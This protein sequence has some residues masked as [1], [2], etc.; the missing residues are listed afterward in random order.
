MRVILADDHAP[1][2]AGV[3]I[4]LEEAG[5]DVVGEAPT[6]RQAVE[7]AVDLQPDICL[8]DVHMPGGNGVW[9]VEEIAS[10]VPE[11]TCV[12]L[13]VSRDDDDLFA[14]L[15]AGAVGYLLKDIDPERLPEALHGAVRGEAALPRALVTRLVD[16]FRGRGQRRVALPGRKAVDLTERELVVLRGL[17]EG[18]TTNEIAESLG[19]APVTIRSYVHTLL[20][21]LRVPDR[22]SA[23]RLFEE[24]ED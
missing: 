20:K 2:R 3:R 15:R 24:A 5:F 11:A 10:K 17:R 21:K 7:L 22:A 16:E 14:A 8:L 23:V 18:R 1:T 13:T 19:V 6:G 12:M 4:S 9:A